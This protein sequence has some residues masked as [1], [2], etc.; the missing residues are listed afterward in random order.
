[1]NKEAIANYLLTEFFTQNP[2]ALSFMT[3]VDITEQILYKADLLD[4]AAVSNIALEV[5]VKQ[6]YISF[7]EIDQEKLYH[8]THQDFMQE[9]LTQ[10]AT[11]SPKTFSTFV[12]KS[13]ISQ[14]IN[15][16]HELDLTN[17]SD[18]SLKSIT[19]E[20]I[21]KLT[22]T[23]PKT[24]DETINKLHSTVQEL[25]HKYISKKVRNAIANILTSK[26]RSLKP[27]ANSVSTESEMT[28]ETEEKIK[29]SI[30]TYRLFGES[31]GALILF[32]TIVGEGYY[33]FPYILLE[34]QRRFDE[35]ISKNESLDVAFDLKAKGRG[36]ATPAQKKLKELISNTFVTRIFLLVED[37]NMSIERA[38]ELLSHSK[39]SQPKVSTETLIDY[40]SRNISLREKL[41]T[42]RKRE[43]D[44]GTHRKI[45][46]SDFST[47]TLKAFNLQSVIKND[48]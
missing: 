1:M 12:T 18:I 43:I 21:H 37:Y 38:A 5:F 27:I 46:L 15:I 28:Y 19:Y 32:N 42:I 16:T 14:L 36:K 3:S 8:I 34:I 30:G 2:E 6:L 35:S 22:S 11:Q 10:A 44:N 20:L 33:P 29:A 26:I 9:L 17:F 25:D 41:M 40:Y 7:R 47:E 45:S 39:E 23:T 48:S 13:N 31:T 4:L 24:S